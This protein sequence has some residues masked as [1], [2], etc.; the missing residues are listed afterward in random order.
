MTLR[1]LSLY[2]L[3]ICANVYPLKR[4]NKECNLDE[5]EPMWYKNTNELGA[6]EELSSVI[7]KTEE[8]IRVN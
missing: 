4:R 6:I 8:K 5:N 7:T 3:P 1:R 2:F